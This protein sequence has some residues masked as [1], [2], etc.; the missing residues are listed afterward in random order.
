MTASAQR[1]RVLIVDDSALVRSLLERA[2]KQDPALEV[3]GTA[4]NPYEARDLLVKLRPDVITLDI[5]MPRMDGISFLRKFMTVM[6]TP[7]VVFSSLVTPDSDLTRRAR[8]AGAVDVVQKPAQNVAD[9]LAKL[10]TTLIAKV[11]AAARTKPRAPLA[12]ASKAEPIASTVLG[13]TTDKVIGIGASTG[14]VA[15]LG[16]L[17]PQFP[18]YTP[19]IVLVQH[20]P[21]GFTRDFAERLAGQCQVRVAEAKDGDRVLR[22][23]V[24]V[25]PGGDAHTEVHRVGGEYRVRLVPGGAVSGHVPSVDVMFESLARA[26][27]GNA[28]GCLLTGMGADGA[29][30]L[31]AMRAQG[32]GTFAQT[33]E[34]CAV[35]GMPAAASALGAVQHFVPLAGMVSALIDASGAR[36]KQQA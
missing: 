20:M 33:R 30:G 17:L 19:G 28:V 6:P 36:E 8:E 34:D 3:V 23:H 29:R 12:G 26:V 18:A 25:A 13:K 31:L 21:A 16:R 14:G 24:L 7:T 5:E 15:A 2:F 11:K 27:G 32:A 4:R 22:G 1:V 10:T 9:G 35:W